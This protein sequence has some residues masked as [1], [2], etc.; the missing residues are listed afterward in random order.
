[1]LM[2]KTELL[3]KLGLTDGEIK[4][5]SFLLSKRAKVTEIVSAT[6]LYRANVY[7]ILDRLIEKGLVSSFSENNVK[8]FEATDAGS[9]S[10]FVESKKRE[11]DDQQKTTAELIPMLKA[12]RPQEEVRINV[13]RGRRGLILVHEDMLAATQKGG[14]I[15]IF[16]AE[17]RSPQHLGKYY[18]AHHRKRIAKKISHKLIASESMRNFFETH[19]NTLTNARYIPKKYISGVNTYIYGKKVALVIWEKEICTVIENED[20]VQSYTNYFDFMW[21]FA[22]K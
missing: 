1:M 13:Y 22:K 19:A 16:G 8:V 9:I 6:G 15:M 21:Q 18:D 14:E 20:I 10:E 17:M 7:E 12:I 11:I 4:I 3:A 2:D 5:Y